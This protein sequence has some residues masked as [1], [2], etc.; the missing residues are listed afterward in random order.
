MLEKITTQDFVVERSCAISRG[1][2]ASRYPRKKPPASGTSPP[3]APPC[4]A[5][6]F[7]EGLIRI[8]TFLAAGLLW[9]AR[10]WLDSLMAAPIIV[11]ALYAGSHVHTRLGD[12]QMLRMVNL[13]LLGSAAAVLVKAGWG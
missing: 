2:R 8:A 13:L 5:C 9:E 6:I 3:C 7:L 1:A 4:P 12:A 11:A 10:T